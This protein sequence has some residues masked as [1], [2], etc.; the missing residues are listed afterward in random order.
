MQQSHTRVSLQS[1]EQRE[2]LVQHLK[3][4][5]ASLCKAARA[6]F[7][8]LQQR[9]YDYRQQSATHTIL[10]D[11]PDEDYALSQKM[12][13]AYQ[14]W[15]ANARSVSGNLEDEFCQ[16][17]AY[18]H[19][20]R[21]FFVC[22]CEDYGLISHSI[23][24]TLFVHRQR[25][26]TELLPGRKDTYIQSLEEAYQQIC[27]VYPKF[28]AQRELYSWFM[29]DE[30]TIKALFTLLDRYDFKGL[31]TDILGRVYNESFIENKARS[32]KGQL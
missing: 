10:L 13:A 12:V 9:H 32:E 22:L 25:P 18:M 28:L 1:P 6:Q 16:Q 7:T 19:F 14:A 3:P 21:I 30:K 26:G 27:V 5:L 11:F 31:S 20:V 29:L 24:D 8:Y 4:V 2:T 23:S 15:K 17:T